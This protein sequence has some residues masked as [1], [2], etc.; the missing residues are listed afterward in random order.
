MQQ[1]PR[2]IDFLLLFFLSGYC[3]LRLVKILSF[4]FRLLFS[5]LVESIQFHSLSFY[6][7]HAF[8]R[9]RSYILVRIC[10]SRTGL[11]LGG[12]KFYRSRGW[13]NA[14]TRTSVRPDTARPTLLR[15][16]SASWFLQKKT[17]PHLLHHRGRVR[18]TGSAPARRG[19]L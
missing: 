7:H 12:V 18:P 6:C 8:C 19:L 14:S 11:K 15:C 4:F 1:S 3:C 16:F 2:G 5:F 13:D 17:A 9:G 10:C